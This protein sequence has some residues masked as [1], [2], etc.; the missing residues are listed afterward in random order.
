M[1]SAYDSR[2]TQSEKKKFM[3]VLLADLPHGVPR[4]STGPDHTIVGGLAKLDSARRSLKSA[5]WRNDSE[6]YVIPMTRHIQIS[7]V[8]VFALMISSVCLCA[9]ALPSCE[10]ASC[11]SDEQHGSCP[12]H[13]QDQDSCSD[14]ECC[15]PAACSSATNLAFD[16]Q[17]LVGNHPSPPL[18]A[19]V[20]AA[21]FDLSSPGLRSIVM[22]AAHS[23]PSS[24]PVF[25]ALRSLLL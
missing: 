9:T 2:G 5:I 10:A 15:Q 7:I 11:A 1:Q 23:P 25:L 16:S 20:R 3:C 12:A 6:S 4:C 22:S 13:Q 18:L 14:H 19:I 21:L 24:V 8:A 17:S